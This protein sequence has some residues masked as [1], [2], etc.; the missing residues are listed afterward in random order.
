MKSSSTLVCV[1]IGKGTKSM[2]LIGR[3][4]IHSLKWAATNTPRLIA[5]VVK[6]WGCGRF[7]GQV[8]RGQKSKTI[9]TNNKNG[10]QAIDLFKE[11]LFAIPA[12]E[13]KWFQLVAGSLFN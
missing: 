2:D 9:F 4:P 8:L 12:C 7:Y 6:G 3:N 11:I 5:Q 1:S 13:K 10:L